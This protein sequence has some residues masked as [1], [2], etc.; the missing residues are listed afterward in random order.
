MGKFFLKNFFSSLVHIQNYQR[1]MGIILRYVCW[2]THRPP[3]PPPRSPAADR[4]TRRPPRFGS[5]QGGGGVP[6]PPWGRRGGPLPPYSPQNCRTPLG[7]THWLAAAP[8]V[9]LCIARQGHTALECRRPRIFLG[10]GPM[11]AQGPIGILLAPKAP[12]P[13]A[14]K[15]I[16][17]PTHPPPPLQPQLPPPVASTHTHTHTHTHTP[18]TCPPSPQH[19]ILLLGQTCV[20]QWLTHPHALTSSGTAPLR[21]AMFCA[22][23]AELCHG[24]PIVCCTWR[25]IL[26]FLFVS[27]ADDT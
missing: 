24:S 16:R 26:F 17:G 4:P 19:Q 6:P 5:T 22:A 11:G 12:P 2:G 1:V 13:R 20:G 23:V 15:G 8:V 27:A 10:C 7:V 18:P 3:P 14:T 21:R 25:P 9:P